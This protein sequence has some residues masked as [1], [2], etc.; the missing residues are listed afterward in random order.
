[1]KH[2]YLCTKVKVETIHSGR[3]GFK[4]SL[5]ILLGALLLF[6]FFMG[7]LSAQ[8]VGGSCYMKGNFVEF[9]VDG[10]GGYE[11][12]RTAL[13]PVPGGYHFRSGNPIFGFV[14]NPQ[15]NGWATFDGDFFTP[16]SPEN[17]WGIEIINGA[18]NLLAS[19]NCS[20]TYWGSP[21]GIPGSITSYQVI[22]N[23]RIVR[24]D[25]DYINGGYNVHI[26]IDYILNILD[27]YYTT[28]LTITNNGLSIPDFYYYR[29]FDP[30][31][32]QSISGD[33]TTSNSIVSQPGGTC[34][35]AHVRATSSVPATQPMS[36]VG[37]AGVGN[38]W[39]AC[40][41]GFANRD[42]S[43]LW[44]GVGFVQAV[45]PV[46]FM[47]EAIALAYR[48]QNFNTGVTETFRFV[49]IL[50]DNAANNAVNNL[51]TVTWPGAPPSSATACNPVVDT[52]TICNGGTASLSVTGSAL[53]SFNWSWSPA[54]G[55]STTTGS[56]TNA[57]PTTS[58]L[59]T[60]TGT[61][62][63]SCF[64]T[65]TQQVFVNVVPGTVNANAG[66]N[67]NLTC[68]TASVVLAGS[69]TTG[70]A[71]FSWSGP[72]I[73]SG[74]T[75]ATPTVN[76]AGV[77]TVTVTSPGGCT[78][79]STTT[80]TLNNTPPNANAGLPQTLTCSATTVVLG[81]S[82]STG[83][84]TATWAGPGIVSGGSTFT[85]TV[86]A[87]G[88]YTITVTNPTNGCTATSTV[89]VSLNNTPPNASAGTPQTLTCT[90]TTVNL[91][92]SSSTGGAT[93]SWSGPGITAGAGTFTPTVN[94]AG[95]YTITVTNPANGCTATSTVLVSLNNTAPNA[96]AGTPQTLTCTTT[97]VNLNGSSSTGGAT[98]AWAGP[99][100]TAGGST[101]T[102]TV[103]TAGTYTITVTNPTN[104]CT[105][106]STV[107]VSLNNTAPNAS[108]GTPQTLTCA[109]T[110]V[111]LNGSSTT[112]GTTAS[113]AGPG[114]T[115]G[116][117]TF[118]PT[119]NGAGTY[120]IT[121]T[122]P[123]N[124]CTST[125]TV[126]VS[127]NNT[128]PNANAGLDQT[129]TCVISSLNL[130]GSS[131]TGG[132][133][134]SWTGPGITAGAT[135]WSPTIN[136]AGNYT[137]TVTNPV[138]GC[139]STDVANVALN[140]TPPNANAGP[141]QN[142]TCSV[143]SLNLAGSSST[144]GATFNWAGPGIVSGGT[145]A[146]PSVNLAGNYTVTVTDPVNGCTSTDV[147]IV[148]GSTLTPNA[149]AGL[150]QT[151]TCTITSLNLN[152][153]STTPGATY[154]WSGP[155]IT[156]GGTTTTPTIN[157]PG[158]YTITVTN[159]T[160][161]C[162]ATDVVN[163]SQ[164]ITAPNA[165][166]GL[167]QTLTCVVTSLNLGGSS[168]TAGAT[169][170]WAGPGITGGGSTATPTVNAA[171]TYTV[172]ITDP[173]N[174]CTST[175]MAVVNLNNT[176]PNVNAGPDQT[177]T[178]VVTSLNL[179]GSSTT[180]GA[181]YAW[182]GPG[183]SS[184]A[185]TS[186]P[187]VNSAGT[188][189]VTVTD[190]VNGCTST[191]MAV[192]NLN[193]TIPNANAGPDDVINCTITN[194]NLSGSSTTPGV[195]YSWSGPAITAGGTT[196]TPNVNG[197]GTYTVIVTDPVNGC[198]NTDQVIVTLNATLPN[199]NAGPDDILNCVVTNV[200]LAGGSTTS[201]VTFA[202]AGPGI[203]AGGTTATPNVN[204]P[205]TYTVTVTNPANG[206]TSTD[207]VIVNQNITAPNSNA[208]LDQTLTCVVTSLNLGGSSST[209]GATFAWA[210]PSITSGATL[211]TPTVNGPGTY[212][213][214]VT[215]PANGCT[216]T[217]VALVN[218]NIVV[219][220]SNAGLDQT[221]T[222]VVTSIN[223]GGSS[224]T[225]GVTYAW[226]GPGISSGGATAT[227][228]VNVAG[229]YTVTVTDPANGC[230]S[231]DVALVNLNNTPPNANAGPDDVLNCVITNINLGGSSTTPGATFAW[232]GPAITSGSATATP[233]VNGAGTYTVTVTDPANGC[234]STDQAVVTLNA[235]LPNATAGPDDIL[236]CVV[237]NLNLA[238]G[239]STAGTTFD[240]NGP[241]IVSGGNTAS[242]NI[243]TPGTYTITVTDPSNGCTNTDVVTVNQDIAIPDADAGTDNTLTCVVTSINLNATSTVGGVTYNW[244]G[245]AI[246]SGGSTN[247][248]SVNGAGVYTVTITNPVNGC[249]NTD[250]VT[251]NLNNTPPDLVMGTNQTIL[252][253][254][255]VVN[256]TGTS[257]TAGV[258]YAWSG[259]GIT[260]G[261]ATST[262]SANAGGTYS[263]MV[264]DPV[265]GCTTTGTVDVIVDLNIPT[266]NFSADNLTSCAPLCATLTDQSLVN[267]SPIVGWNWNVESIGTSDLQGGTFC[268]NDPGMYD[269]TLTVTTADGCTSTLNL[270]N[271]LTVHPN[272]VA[273]FM[274]APQEILITD[275]EV[276]FG[277]TSSGADNYLWEFGDG[278]TSTADSP[279]HMYADTGTYCVTLNA[280]TNFGCADTITHCLIVKPEY[281]LY[282]PN[283]FTANDDG[284][285]DQWN[286]Y[287]MGVKTFVARIFDRW[288][289]EI[290]SFDTIDKGW[291]GTM[292]NGNP[293]Q[294]GVYVYKI[295]V[296]DHLGDYHEYYGNVN[297]IR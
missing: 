170:A 81:G 111:N 254:T 294:Q 113:W 3:S 47:D 262:A 63:T 211:A 218:Q 51:F 167:D 274:Y 83:G 182:T 135:T 259:P 36:Y 240:W 70:G 112:P 249:T 72:G 281:T 287:G 79:S 230:T 286:V 223:L 213:V 284:L 175:D 151:L 263:V 224:T 238:G 98:A 257:A 209:P 173:A 21:Y 2:L 6:Y 279:K 71:T 88:T 292:Q 178:C 196:A 55:L 14:S 226:S 116:G 168:S 128:P 231:T 266:A 29:N 19:N 188:Y 144:P 155:G 283:S 92:G 30:D 77:Y 232:A 200:N 100:I 125:N 10:G 126:L 119:V 256:V 150:D 190:P 127:L 206:C 40:Y 42:G 243:N 117:T 97:T 93:A 210:G 174:G 154:A 32:N 110:S 148:N 37:L 87:V 227:P 5:L 124:G 248:P 181:T 261:A 11:G 208:G 13:S 225:P 68:T 186:T 108:A 198:T 64:N 12:V 185:A 289:E 143:T 114:I 43:N 41:G 145:T 106:T 180:P 54:T 28:V 214:T 297:L 9:A 194:I 138:N 48:I 251:I 295:V 132:V 237:T 290:Y 236:N 219:P 131:S 177:L 44:N 146:T 67:M 252:C 101:F 239:S 149:N 166:A 115:A 204:A 296:Q 80:V 202:W 65:V 246:V 102:P 260:G 134:C 293:C 222:C 59:Y 35:K 278:N 176:L 265:N 136:V 140:N 276:T 57:S 26:R 184:G 147:V 258:S 192:V 75:T 46:N 270:A 217:D 78:T 165:N 163:V 24:W 103:N 216:S 212:T 8:M 152:G 45:G 269:V 123:T 34:N 94:M 187:T 156:A 109:V 272:P 66:P 17:G 122:N 189:T 197:A 104:G 271:Y 60:V 267:G 195:T 282:I 141:D 234:T 215:D 199:A 228:T 120:T 91:N 52:V 15:A 233:N 118:T 268:F 275:P 89:A 38:N 69:S 76:A 242:P 7:R 172:T 280:E 61:P 255:P 164:N 157:A 139:T 82:S 39:R 84:A 158:N 16:G 160:N 191:D 205:G 20:D 250:I 159:P 74:A 291:P 207:V 253:N 50:D 220:N 183:V 73:V 285:N 130:S 221:L 245:P 121:V 247:A 171:G 33:F 241:G 90:A 161:G 201:G 4:K 162:T 273:D 193:N 288:G 95:T 96:N 107:V 25:G 264:T 129:L 277:N 229:N 62:T 58:T 18:T 99:G 27:L 23:C 133:T 235:T 86:N 31:N 142:L 169:F 203:T 244:N 53:S 85:P 179:N 56:T 1:M 105:A 137:I 22:G 49:T 153:S